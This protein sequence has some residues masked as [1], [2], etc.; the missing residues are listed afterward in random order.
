M[1]EYL[2]G[3]LNDADR[4][5][6]EDLVATDASAKQEFE[7]LRKMR[8]LLS[9]Q[10]KIEPNPSFWTRLSA[11]LPQELEEDNLLPFPRRHFPA[12]ALASIAGIV[13]IGTVIFQNRMSL[14]HFMSQKSQLVQSAYEEGIMKGS[15]LPLLSHIDNNQVLQFSLLGVLPLDAKS[16]TALKVDQNS[17]NGYQI[18]LG[19]S[20]PSKSSSINVKD[21]YAEIQATN[22]QKDVIDSLFGLARR[23]IENSVLVSENHA[24]AIDPALAQLNRVM[25][26]NIASCLEPFQ[27]VR[28]GR[29]L[30]RKDAPYTF[31]S[32]KFV[33]ANPESIYVEMSRVP[34]TRRFVVVTADTLTYANL[35]ADVL[36]QIQ[37]N[38][39]IPVETE[40]IARRNLEM[41]ERL[42][43]HFAEREPRPVM[44]R[45]VNPQFEIWKDANT[46][47]IQFQRDADEPRWEIR[48]PVVVPMPRRMGTYSLTSPAG[49]FEFG[50][51][52]DSVTAGEVMIDSAMVRFFN[53]DNAAAYN[54][55]MMDSIF[56]TLNARFQMH[57]GAFP[58]DSV[59]RT[60][61]EARRRTFEE[62]KHRQQMMQ[63]EVR[64]KKKDSSSNER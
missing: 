24:V 8:T 53:S 42:L 3:V 60:V 41:T 15:I 35:D 46:V 38:V 43:R 62:G 23:K 14:F 12:A 52:G 50:F 4:K 18:K 54:L 17:S 58:L 32:K 20:T 9:G 45:M 27:R 5:A 40:G 11:S 31:V 36:R 37:H 48:Q 26:S 61:E 19:K 34:A 21:F 57:P 49:R 59:L 6:I 22:E 30:E 51:Y 63:Q 64:L 29:F 56:T 33:P 25:V 1:Q 7:R 13:L 16:Q 55:R 47:S 39:E 44:P 10:R 2:D 28:F